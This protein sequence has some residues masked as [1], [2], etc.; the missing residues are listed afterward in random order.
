MLT[1]SP[2]PTAA[3]GRLAGWS[4]ERPLRSLPAWRRK[5]RP[6]PGVLRASTTALLTGRLPLGS[7]PSATLLSSFTCIFFLFFYDSCDTSFHA[8]YPVGM[9]RVLKPRLP[10][11]KVYV[12]HMESS[13]IWMTP[14]STRLLFIWLLGH[15]DEDGYIP[16]MTHP[17]I[18]RLANLAEA[19]VVE[20]L[21]VL[22]SPDPDSRTPDYDGRRLLTLDDGGWRAVNIQAYRE[23]RTPKQIYDAERQAKLRAAKRP[24]SRRKTPRE[25]EIDSF[26]AVTGKRDWT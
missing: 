25:R 3:P 21:R 22:T 20:G 5:S 2:R 16:R 18:A 23:M 26:D 12:T 17:N 7:F 24:S 13:S 1:R 6:P 10:F 15:A 19:D 8:C 4:G 9:P 11:V 14:A